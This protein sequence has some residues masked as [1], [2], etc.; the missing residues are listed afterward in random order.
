MNLLQEVIKSI[1]F[2][3]NP[4]NGIDKKN[5]TEEEKKM[6]DFPKANEEFLIPDKINNP[7]ESEIKNIH[8]NI[9][10]SF[11]ANP[12]NEDIEKTI[13]QKP[14]VIQAK[15]TLKLFDRILRVVQLIVLVAVISY[16]Y[17]L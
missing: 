9:N 16:I 6:K 7:E 4:L 15:N 13:E 12:N 1:K 2:S 17:L 3:K 8:P 5:N 14:E 10:N 11:D